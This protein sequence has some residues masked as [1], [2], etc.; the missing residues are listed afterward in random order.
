MYKLFMHSPQGKKVLFKKNAT[1]KTNKK[2]Y[3]LI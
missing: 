3:G 1:Y 2:G